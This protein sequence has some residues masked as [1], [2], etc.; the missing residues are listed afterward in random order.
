M[1][2]LDSLNHL[3]GEQALA[4]ALARVALFTAPGGLFVFDVN[5]AYKHRE[6]LADNTFV[7]DLDDV[8]CIWQNQ[9]SS[10]DGRVDIRLDFFVPD[11]EWKYDRF[12]EGFSERFFSGELLGRLL[13]ENGFD[14]LTVYGDDG[15]EAPADTTQRAVYVARRQ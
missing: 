15:D 1:C 7:Y 12:S 5:T 4:A 6:V 10:D 11:D 14:L 3:P 2:A 9:Y 8:Y 13:A